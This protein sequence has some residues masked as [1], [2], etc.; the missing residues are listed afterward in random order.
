MLPEGQVEAL[1]R[2]A[3]GTPGYGITV[4]LENQT[5]SDTQGFTAHFDVDSF[6][7]DCLLSGLTTL[8]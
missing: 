4:D 6:R 7:R 3:Q 8:G 1:M 2:R 5:V